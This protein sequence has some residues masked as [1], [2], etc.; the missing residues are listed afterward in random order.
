MAGGVMI[1]YRDVRGPRPHDGV[2]VAFPFVVGGSGGWVRLETAYVMSPKQSSW[3]YR[4]Q[5]ERLQGNGPV[6]LGI[7][8]DLNSW[9]LR[10]RGRLSHGVLGILI[11]TT[12]PRR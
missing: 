11:G 8:L 3:N 2:E 9:E 5:W 1:G 6:T 12:W 10:N 7:R 4:L